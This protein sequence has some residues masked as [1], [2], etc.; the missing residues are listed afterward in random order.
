VSART[1][2]QTRHDYSSTNTLAF[3]SNVTAGSLLIVASLGSSSATGNPTDSLGN[4]YTLAKKG[5]A[6]GSGGASVWYA[7]S[8]TGGACTVTFPT[9]G[10][11][12]NDLIELSGTVGESD[13]FDNAIDY[14]GGIAESAANSSLRPGNLTLATPGSIAVF[15]ISQFGLS[16]GSLSSAGSGYTLLND[17]EGHVD[18]AQ[19]QVGMAAGA[20][21]TGFVYTGSTKFSYWIAAGFKDTGGAPPPSVA[22]F[23]FMAGGY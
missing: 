22:A 6:T 9:I 8:V 17:D 1:V 4:T 23:S 10:D 16:V 2:I 3:S 13:P 21:A 7:F 12:A 11:Q 5:D 18:A 15:W 14:V 20:Q 19:Y